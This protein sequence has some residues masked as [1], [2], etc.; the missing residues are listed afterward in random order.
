MKITKKEIKTLG[1]EGLDV[2]YNEISDELLKTRA[3][4]ASGANPKD[5]H[6]IGNLRK[7]LAR[8]LTFK[9]QKEAKQ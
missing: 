1:A 3:Q 4:S 6:A 5:L 8:I 2:K 9:K 7:T